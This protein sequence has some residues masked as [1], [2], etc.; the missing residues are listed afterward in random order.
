MSSWQWIK[1]RNERYG[2]NL[3]VVLGWLSSLGKPCANI[4]RLGF[5]SHLG[6]KN[7]KHLIRKKWM[8]I[9]SKFAN[10]F[11]EKKISPVKTFFGK[12]FKFWAKIGKTFFYIFCR[13]GCLNN[14]LP[15]ATVT[16]KLQ[17]SYKKVTKKLQ[18]TF[19]PFAV[20]SKAMYLISCSDLDQLQILAL[21]KHS[22]L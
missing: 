10:F 12:F 6:H 14:P 3:R 17:K 1:W 9:F 8:E 13:V 5:R 20:G 7:L 2:P 19:V 4:C 21:M 11:S 22:L 16:K 18:K 15:V